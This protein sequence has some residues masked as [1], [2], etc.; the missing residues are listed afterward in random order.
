MF[1]T[2]DYR[3]VC[4]TVI[5]VVFSW[6]HL[7]L[8]PEIKEESVGSPLFREPRVVLVSYCK[9]ADSIFLFL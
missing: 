5:K 6:F 3:R 7:C 8:I 9:T 1:D 2:R 4:Q